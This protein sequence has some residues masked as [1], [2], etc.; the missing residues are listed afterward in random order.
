VILLLD[1]HVLLWSLSA[2]EE[3]DSRS[4]RAIQDP[5]NDVMV[6]TASIWELEIKRANGKLRFTADLI[7]DAARAG[8][9]VIPIHAADAI[10][11]ARL[12]AHHRDPFDRM[13]VAQAARLDAVILTRDRAFAAYDIHVLTA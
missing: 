10:A 11:A 7:V 4:V 5:S 3:L 13:L 2:V 8:F 6:S 9:D 12:P 1:A